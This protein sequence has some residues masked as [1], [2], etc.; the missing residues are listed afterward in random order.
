MPLIHTCPQVKL[1]SLIYEVVPGVLTEHGKTKNPWPNVDAHSGVLLQYYNLTEYN[2]YTVLFGVS[3]GF[4]CLS[5]V[6][7]II[8]IHVCWYGCS[9]VLV[10]PASTLSLCNVYAYLCYA[11]LSTYTYVSVFCMSVSSHSTKSSSCHVYTSHTCLLCSTSG[12]EPLAYPWSAP[13]ASPASG[14]IK[15]SRKCTHTLVAS[16]CTHAHAIQY[17]SDYGIYTLEMVVA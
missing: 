15:S 16:P 3:R 13:R 6:R 5:Q 10:T 14:S 7:M 17:K 4:G 11:Y 12:I 1:V 8:C 2:Y 9:C